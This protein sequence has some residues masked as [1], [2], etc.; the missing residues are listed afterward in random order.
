M[1]MILSFLLFAGLY[2]LASVVL[3]R[4]RALA[5]LKEQAPQ[6]LGLRC[7]A[8]FGWWLLAYVLPNV[9]A[10]SLWPGVVFFALLVICDVA[11]LA[12]GG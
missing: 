9:W 1:S 12:T 3:L 5:Q 8:Y 11:L 4:R 2:A 10:P 7:F 6:F